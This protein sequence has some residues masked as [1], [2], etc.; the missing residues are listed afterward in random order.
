MRLMHTML[1]ANLDALDLESCG[2]QG[3][4]GK[5][6]NTQVCCMLQ[7]SCALVQCAILSPV[8]PDH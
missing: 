7:R 8:Q 4:E 2:K 3:A 5:Q 6:D 1:S